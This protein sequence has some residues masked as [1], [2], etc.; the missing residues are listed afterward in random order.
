MNSK[1]TIKDT[2]ILGKVLEERM[3]H[4]IQ[5]LAGVQ[6]ELRAHIRKHTQLW[7]FAIPTLIMIAQFLYVILMTWRH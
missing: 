7:L 6:R 1:P 3:D 5:L 2:Y 4:F